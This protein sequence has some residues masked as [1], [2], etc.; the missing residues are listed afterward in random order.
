VSGTFEQVAAQQCL[1]QS[2]HL[3]IGG[4]VESMAPVIDLYASEF[5]AARV[6]ADAVSLFD[7]GDLVSFPRQTQSGAET[8][9]ACSQ[10]NDSSHAA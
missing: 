1:N 9:R 4:G 7:D 3:W 2:K 6:A 5:E 10:N 8:C